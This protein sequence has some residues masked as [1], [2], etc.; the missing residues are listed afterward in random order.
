[1]ISVC[2]P[3]YNLDVRELVRSLLVQAEQIPAE[4]I[5]IDDGSE[6]G[7]RQLNR[8]LKGKDVQYHELGENIGRARI[9]NLFP[10]YAGYSHLLFL[11]CDSVILNERFLGIYADEI[12]AEGKES[13]ICGGRIYPD[14]CPSRN[15]RLHWK[16]G[17][18][19]ESRPAEDRR[20]EP[21][22]SFMSNN[23]LV[24]AKI[25]AE[26]PF[27]EDLRN[28]GHEDSLFGFELSR[29][30][31]K[32]H[33]IDNPILHGDLQTNREFTGKTA[34]AVRN[35]VYISEMLDHDPEFTNS[36]NL[37]RTVKSFEKK[38]IAGMLTL[39]SAIYVP[40]S[41]TM[42][43]MGCCCLRLLDLYKLGLCLEEMKLQ[44]N[45]A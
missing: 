34:E 20:R 45:L 6:L 23:F 40:L 39:L 8:S 3:V 16:Y 25:L 7:F 1:M 17:I 29:K 12:S 2:I 28:Y 38:G 4:I 32:I 31:L 14:S 9:R 43:N 22:V 36:I 33:H 35:L 41:R 19:K 5:L 27:N 30:R 26:N 18:K 10:A 37:L 13:I 42:L 21:N 15:R 44:K 24:P 11:D